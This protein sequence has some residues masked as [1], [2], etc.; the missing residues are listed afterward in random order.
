MTAHAPCNHWKPCHAQT[1]RWSDARKLRSRSEENVMTASNKTDIC[2]DGYCTCLKNDP[3]TTSV[4]QR[5]AINNNKDLVL[6]RMMQ[7]P[8]SQ[9]LSCST[10]RPTLREPLVRRGTQASL[11]VWRLC[12]SVTDSPAGT[13]RAVF[14]QILPCR[15]DASQPESDMDAMASRGKY[16]F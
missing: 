10:L 2:P 13:V 14:C 4:T 6:D 1:P 12:V 7:K 11:R 15:A 8:S 16:C 5:T 3:L 9:T